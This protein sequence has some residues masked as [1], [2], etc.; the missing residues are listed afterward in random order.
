LTQGEIQEATQRLEEVIQH[1]AQHFVA[2]KLLAEI[3][4]FHQD[5]RQAAEYYRRASAIQ[6]DDSEC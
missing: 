2:H 5:Y 4:M 1:D 3:T 6:P